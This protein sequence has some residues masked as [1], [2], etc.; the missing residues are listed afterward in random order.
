MQS[1]RS[2]VQGFSVQIVQ[3]I[4]MRQSFHTGIRLSS[5]KG[6]SREINLQVC[7]SKAP[8]RVLAGGRPVDYQGRPISLQLAREL[9]GDR[10][11]HS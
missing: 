7:S 5:G 3:V 2:P 4:A 8:G 10:L 9:A 11:E 1:H 6:S